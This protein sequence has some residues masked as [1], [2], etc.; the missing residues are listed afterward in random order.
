MRV[1]RV[2]EV[3]EEEEGGKTEAR[4]KTGRTIK[5]NIHRWLSG[6]IQ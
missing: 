5:I 2:K 3:V 1:I 6:S 4:R